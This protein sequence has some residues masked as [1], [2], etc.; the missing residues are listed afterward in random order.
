M[1]REKITVGQCD[2]CG[3]RVE[4][5]DATTEGGWGHLLMKQI[6]GPQRIGLQNPGS[7]PSPADICTGCV[8]DLIKWWDAPNPKSERKAA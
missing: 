1:S 4:F 6:N 8:T 7:E 2:R 5:R 3:C